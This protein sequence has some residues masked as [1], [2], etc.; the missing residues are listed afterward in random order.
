MSGRLTGVGTGPGAPDLMTLRAVETVR[1][2]PVVAYL[3]ADGK[4]SRARET[5]AAA[6]RPG[7]PEIVIAMPMRPDPA[8]GAAA[9]DDGAAR[10]AGELAAG[11]DV[12]CLCE[13]DPLLYGSFIHLMERL[14][15]RFAVDI[16][17][18][19]PSFAACAALARRPLARREES[20][21]ILPA[22]MDD[23]ALA[24]RLL[25]LDSA[26]LIK[27]GRHAGRIRALLDRL[28][29]LDGAVVV[30]EASRTG[31]VIRPMADCGDSLPYFATVL[32]MREK[33]P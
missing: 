2:A 29:L 33:R 14:Q 16:V 15:D 9:Y 7:T 32:V 23:D 22:T 3:S 6:I 12:A 1:A 25:L 10:I 11:R 13:G 20:F 8:A 17:P 5:A 24:A 27:T 28:G 18:G 31:Q 30:E 19:L 26:A 21:A 4:P